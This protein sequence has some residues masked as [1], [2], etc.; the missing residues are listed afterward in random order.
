MTIVN[1]AF[2]L[3]S[4]YTTSMLWHGINLSNEEKMP[5]CYYN[6]KEGKTCSIRSHVFKHG[7]ANI[8]GK[9]QSWMN[10]SS[11]NPFKWPSPSQPLS[12]QQRHFHLGRYPMWKGDSRSISIAQRSWKI[13]NRIYSLLN[14]YLSSWDNYRREWS[15]YNEMK[16][17][18]KL[19]QHS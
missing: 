8:L 17:I 12:S 10:C 13:T 18:S 4:H 7:V 6:Y 9:L 2:Q 15:I 3:T 11:S 14:P 5:M 1:R 16:R 19:M